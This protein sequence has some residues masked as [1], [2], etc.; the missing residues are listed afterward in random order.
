[1]C[2]ASQPLSYPYKPLELSVEASSDPHHTLAAQ[3]TYT[4]SLMTQHTHTTHNAA[5]TTASL[6]ADDC[7]HYVECAP[8]LTNASQ[9]SYLHLLPPEMIERVLLPRLAYCADP[10]RDLPCLRDA[11]LAATAEE[12]ALLENFSKSKEALAVDI[13]STPPMRKRATCRQCF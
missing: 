8:L 6:K 3:Y 7:L 12:R 9:P 2:V 5:D 10:W 13:K 11:R 1:M 4:H